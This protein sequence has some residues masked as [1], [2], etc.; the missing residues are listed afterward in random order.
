VNRLFAV[1]TYLP[2]FPVD[3]PP[4]DAETF[5]AFIAVELEHFTLETLVYWFRHGQG[6]VVQQGEE[7]AE[8]ILAT[9]PRS[10][11]H[12]LAEVSRHDRLAGA[13]PFVAQLVGALALPPRRRAE[14][15]LPLGGYH[16][17]GTRGQ[18]EQ[19]LPGQFALDELEFLR[20]HA[21][22]EL[23]YYRREEP[24][25]RTRERIVLLL[26]QGVRTWGRVRLALVA[27]VFALGELVQRKRLSLLV[28]TTV[29]GGRAVDPLE[30]PAADLAELLAGTDLGITPALALETLLESPAESPRDFLLLT[31]PRNL[32]CPEVATAARRLGRDCRLFV[33]AVSGE[34]EVSFSELRHGLPLALG[35]FHQ[36][37]DAAPP[38]QRAEPTGNWSGDIER[39][40]R[41]PSASGW[42][43]A[44]SSSC[45]PSTRPANG[46]S[47]P[48]RRGSCWP[49]AWTDKRMRC[50]PGR[51]YREAC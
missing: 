5:E 51:S 34:G 20:R 9:K 29:N 28:S 12:A 50:C 22:N 19:I 27:C 45:S 13:V 40:F 25:C 30:L 49:C 4:L 26:D 32:A 41:S 24:A 21:E 7:L 6:P 17:V 1:R 38:P 46:C 35:Q 47:W 37:L 18:P 44:T 48:P 39:M 3:E 14:P 11:A 10:L 8:E 43:P 31:H 33:V 42:A 36:D 15:E 23:L 2:V 16:D